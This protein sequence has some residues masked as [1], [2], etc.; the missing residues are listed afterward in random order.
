MLL[1]C[2]DSGGRELKDE[3]G[4]Y[5]GMAPESALVGGEQGLAVAIYLTKPPARGVHNQENHLLKLAKPPADLAQV[6]RGRA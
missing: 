6:Y 3:Y 1:C 2:D 5:D 4:L